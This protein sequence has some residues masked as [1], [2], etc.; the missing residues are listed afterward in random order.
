MPT[1]FLETTHPRSALL[2]R[3][4]S[5]VYI[6]VEPPLAEKGDLSEILDLA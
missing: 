5:R 6:D 2:G 3:T 4:G 1:V